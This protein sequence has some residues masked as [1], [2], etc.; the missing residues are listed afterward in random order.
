MRILVT[1]K[2]GQVGT[3]LAK[4]YCSDGEVVFSGR[5]EC[6]LSQEQSIRD[7]VRRVRPEIIVNAGAYT[8]VDKAE[9][10]QELCFAVNA[11]APAI[12]AEEAGRLGAL[13]IHYSTDYVFNGQKAG[14]YTESDPVDPINVYG[15]SKAAG[16]AAILGGDSH[17]LV[18]RTTWVYAA[19]GKNFLRTMLRLGAERPVLTVVDD[20]TGAPTSA[21][22]IA[23]MTRRLAKKYE[24]DRE[25][26]P[27]G[28]YHMSAGG[29]TT[30]CGFARAIFEAAGVK[31]K[32]QV[33]PIP[34]S[35]YKTPARRPANSL[36]ANDKFAQTFGFRMT[37][38][39]EQLDEVLAT[40]KETNQ[41]KG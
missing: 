17:S 16:E 20:Q 15:A 33:D 11:K 9:S 30:W 31:N 7:A 36:L 35:A 12:L 40:M 13:L 8:A 22:A 24:E 37:D 6:D 19:E 29:S 38:W 32:P 21:G 3:E 10:D 25:S 18:L 28:L 23:A 26:V 5:A 34:S 27:R 39:R 4:L 2:G 1:G 41:E 14:P